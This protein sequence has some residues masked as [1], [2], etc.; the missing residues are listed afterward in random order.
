MV[1][2]AAASRRHTRNMHKGNSRRYY[3][4]QYAARP[5]FYSKWSTRLLLRKKKF[6]VLTSLPLVS[7]CVRTPSRI[8]KLL[9]TYIRRTPLPLPF[10]TVT[11]LTHFLFIST[12]AF[13]RL[14][15]RPAVT[16]M[17]HLRKVCQIMILFLW[18]WGLL[19][20]RRQNLKTALFPS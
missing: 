14:Y 18:L 8:N 3:R 11:H 16:W 4:L 19:P 9:F 17:L 12:K 20:S 15:C 2:I 13:D 7:S 10:P 6:N 1:R 5:S